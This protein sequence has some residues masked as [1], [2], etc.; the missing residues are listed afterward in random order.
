MRKIKFVLL[1]LASCLAVLAAD[2]V[3]KGMTEAD[4]LEYKGKPSTKASVGD[5]TIYRWADMEVTLRQGKVTAIKVRDL[6]AERLDEERRQKVIEEAKAK[7]AEW[8]AWKATHP[9]TSDHPQVAGIPKT[10][11][12]IAN[13]RLKRTELISALRT[14]IDD[15][16]N[17]LNM[18]S[19]RFTT[20]NTGTIS[21]EQ[22]DIAQAKIMKLEAQ[23]AELEAQ[24]AQGP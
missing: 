3:A 13:E 17:F 21:S 20:P 10:P 24:Q 7:E 12:E 23:V 15:Q 8:L 11:L 9:S 6:A 19:Q 14:Q 1:F 22:R 5:K 4:L 18:Y 16:R 2:E